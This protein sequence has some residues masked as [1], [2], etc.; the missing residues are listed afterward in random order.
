MA[1]C[2]SSGGLL[3]PERSPESVRSVRLAGESLD[4]VPRSLLP[5]FAGNFCQ[6]LRSSC[7]LDGEAGEVEAGVLSV[8]GTRPWSFERG[9]GALPESPPERPAPNLLQPLRSPR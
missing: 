5:L 8:R 6:P 9:D 3:P 4:L 1:R 7:V 2:N